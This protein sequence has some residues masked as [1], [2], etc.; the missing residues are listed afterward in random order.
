MEQSDTENIKKTKGKKKKEEPLDQYVCGHCDLTTK[1]W[2]EFENHSKIMH[3]IST[4]FPCTV[5]KCYKVYLSKNGLK[6]HC[7]REH[8]KECTCTICDFVA[9]GPAPL[10]DHV[11]SHDMKKFKCPFCTKGFGSS[12]D[13]NHHQ[14]KCL[15]NPNRAIT[16]KKCLEKGSTIDV[17]GAEAGLVLHL[18]TE[19]RLKGD[20]LCLLCHKLY[21][22]EKR[23][24]THSDKCKKARG[25]T[26]EISSTED[27]TENTENDET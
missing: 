23:F 3:R 26:K 16:C 13:Q 2:D 11:K 24:D 20:W 5:K 6:G 1:D 9:H 25:K 22:T 17:S 15:Q 27:D 8:K 12:Y 14:V 19:H 21:I 4:L 7:G 10:K 18:Q